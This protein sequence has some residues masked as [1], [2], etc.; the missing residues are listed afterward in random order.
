MLLYTENPNVCNQT[1]RVKRMCVACP[2]GKARWKTKPNNMY[3][4]VYR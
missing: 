1:M 4:T 2:R 3:W